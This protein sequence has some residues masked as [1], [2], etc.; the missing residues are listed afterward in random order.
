MEAMMWHLALHELEAE[1]QVGSPVAAL[2]CS[3][4]SNDPRSTEQEQENEFKW[5][6]KQRRPIPRMTRIR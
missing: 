6:R 3:D 4:C 2:L 1:D 5:N